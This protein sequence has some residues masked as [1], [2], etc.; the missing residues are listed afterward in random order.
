MQALLSHGPGGPETLVL[1]DG[2]PEPRPEP[3][4]AVVAVKAC[5]VNFMDALIIQDLYQ[6]RP[7]RP[8]APGA[9]IA[10][11]VTALG[12]GVTGLAVGDRVLGSMYAGGMASALAVKATDLVRI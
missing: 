7:A 5:G 6:H 11:V 1:T 8:F 9:E 10:G 4:Q 3:G 12:E 2:L